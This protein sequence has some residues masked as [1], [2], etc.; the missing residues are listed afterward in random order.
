MPT[1]ILRDHVTMIETWDGVQQ[2]TRLLAVDPGDVHVGVAFFECV[3]DPSVDENWECVDTLETDPVTFEDSLLETLSSGEVDILVAE[4]FE[5]YE[6][7]ALAQTGSPMRTAQ[8]LGVIR[9]AHRICETHATNHDKA[10]EA[11]KILAC[12]LQGNLCADPLEQT[13]KHIVLC[14]WQMASIQE[15][16]AGNLRRRKIKSVAKQ[17]GDKLGHQKSAE[18][19]GWH[20][21]LHTRHQ[22]P[23][24]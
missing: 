22:P 17:N 10:R 5:L 15:P 11:G 9:Y 4:E 1:N 6:S 14:D 7:R 21:I 13:A 2:F 18:L 3:G 19:H 23:R 24:S 12:Q 16:T 20:Y 8:M